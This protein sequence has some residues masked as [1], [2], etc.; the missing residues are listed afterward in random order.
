MFFNSEKCFAFRGPIKYFE[1]AP[2][3]LGWSDNSKQTIF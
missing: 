1:P 2:L 3:E